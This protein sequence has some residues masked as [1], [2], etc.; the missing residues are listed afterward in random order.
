MYKFESSQKKSRA[1]AA[2]SP[3]AYRK[4]RAFNSIF[5]DFGFDNPQKKSLMYS[6]VRMYENWDSLP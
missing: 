6:E 3:K 5:K 1:L 2:D 4:P